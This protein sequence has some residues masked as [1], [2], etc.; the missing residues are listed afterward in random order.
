MQQFLPYI[1]LAISVLLV[2]AILL[3]QR[4]AGAGSA[5]GGDGSVYSTRRGLEK[6]LFIATIILGFLFF[7]SAALS[8]FLR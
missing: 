6:K 3:Q 4:S 1:Q 5:F 7:V 2:G 8:I